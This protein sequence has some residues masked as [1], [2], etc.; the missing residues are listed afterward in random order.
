MRPLDLF[1]EIEISPDGEKWIKHKTG[2]GLMVTAED[3]AGMDDI[4]PDWTVRITRLK[5]K[6]T[7]ML[8]RTG[9]E[10]RDLL[11]ARWKH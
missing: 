10:M 8:E 7:M 6:R 4:P 2:F 11:R 5:I 9:Q 3:V 1:Y